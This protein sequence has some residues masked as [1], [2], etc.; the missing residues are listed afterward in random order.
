MSGKSYRFVIDTDAGTKRFGG[1]RERYMKSLLK[2]AE[3]LPGEK[4]DHASPDL[5]REVHSIKGVAGNLGITSLYE[6]AI[7][8]EEAL[9]SEDL[10]E[11]AYD[12]FYDI[13]AATGKAILEQFDDRGRQA[14]EQRLPEGTEIEYDALTFMLRSALEEGDISTAEEV[15]AELKSKRWPGT[16]DIVRLCNLVEAYEFD[17]A[18]RL[19]Q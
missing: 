6:A 12:L 11:A 16:L 2:F 7:A 1:K 19:L 10:A 5:P 3:G 14:E 13:C 4:L 15:T 9:K 18:L 17:A 8:C